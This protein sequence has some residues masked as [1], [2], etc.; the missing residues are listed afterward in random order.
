ME[1]MG[2]VPLLLQTVPHAVEKLLVQ[3]VEVAIYARNS[4][5]TPQM[6]GKHIPKNIVRNTMVTA[7]PNRMTLAMIEA[8]H[9]PMATTTTEHLCKPQ[10]GINICQQENQNDER[11]AHAC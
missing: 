10:G 6:R 7:P 11:E 5:Q 4:Q 3:R 2:T 1:S 8:V 9:I